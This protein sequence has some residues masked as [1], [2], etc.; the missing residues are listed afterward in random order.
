MRILATLFVLFLSVPALAED[1]PLPPL[2][3]V[4][5]TFHVPFTTF[6]RFDEA[7]AGTESADKSLGNLGA[8]LWF[9][10]FRRAT[11]MSDS[12]AKQI[13]GRVLI[14]AGFSV[15][16]GAGKYFQN[17]EYNQEVRAAYDDSRCHGT[18]YTGNYYIDPTTGERVNERRDTWGD[19]FQCSDY[20]G[21]CYNRAVHSRINEITYSPGSIDIQAEIPFEKGA[22]TFAPGIGWVGSITKTGIIDNDLR[23]GLAN[24]L[25]VSGS[26]EWNPNGI[27]IGVEFDRGVLG[28]GMR[29]RFKV[30]GVVAW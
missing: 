13:L 19:C 4:K 25:I 11:E 23:T 14:G 24:A 1:R 8:A 6:E 27:G 21:L 17:F 5:V 16:K 3:P 29:N 28:N 15:N 2:F 30:K 22:F 10:P 7:P 26:A 9:Q 20:N 18:E 12:K